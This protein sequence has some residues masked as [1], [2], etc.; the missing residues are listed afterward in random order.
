MKKYLLASVLTTL[1]VCPLSVVYATDIVTK[2]DIRF[3]YS[4]EITDGKGST[5]LA[6]GRERLRTRVR[7]GAEKEVNDQVKGV[8]RFASGGGSLKSTNADLT[9]AKFTDTTYGAYIDLAY[10]MYTPYESPL[11]VWAGKIA[12]PFKSTI[13]LWDG[14][15]NLPGFAAKGTFG[16]ANLGLGYFVVSENNSAASAVGFNDSVLLAVQTGYDLP[17]SDES[18]LGVY[19]S[20]YSIG[21]SSLFKDRIG[22]IIADYKINKNYSVVVDVFNNFRTDKT[23]ETLGG[24]VEGKTKLSEA[25][26]ASIGYGLVQSSAIENADLFSDSDFSS[27]IGVNNNRGVKATLGYKPMK[28]NELNLTVF[29]T[30]NGEATGSSSTIGSQTVILADWVVKI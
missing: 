10:L 22:E 1:M 14:D 13:L 19:A 27:L 30:S 20:F 28:D 25:L 8:V 15:T 12:N 16:A 3:R 9:L 24:Y 4:N 26:Q 2:G 6:T 7:F 18:V 23:V 17:L 11:T 5:S 21:G 29:V